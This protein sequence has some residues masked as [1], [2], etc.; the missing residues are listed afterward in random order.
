[1]KDRYEQAGEDPPSFGSRPAGA[2]RFLR[3]EA[4]FVYWEL[5]LDFPAVYRRVEFDIEAAYY[6][7]A[8][9]LWTRQTLHAALNADW[10]WS[11]HYFRWGWNEPGHWAPG[12][13]TLELFLW[14]ERIAA[15]QFEI[16]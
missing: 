12:R 9:S 2:V 5:V 14:N 13:Y 4:R 11:H 7:P 6:D 3:D 15:A 16:V 10:T 1:M 8:G